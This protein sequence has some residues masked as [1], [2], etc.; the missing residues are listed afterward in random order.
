MKRRFMAA[1]MALGLLVLLVQDVPLA[2]YLRGVET[3]RITTSL[4]RDAFVLAGRSEEALQSTDTADDEAVIAL[5]HQ[6]RASGGARVVIV[7]ASG[8]A[9]VTSDDDQSGVGSTY[10]TRPEI[11]QAMAGTVSNGS[12]FSETLQ[13]K[14][15]YV[16]V[17]VLSGDEVLGAVRL[18]Y[19]ESVVNAAVNE[20]VKRLTI[21]ALTTVVLAGIAAYVLTLSVTRQLDALRSATVALAE[22]DLTSRADE[23]RGAP[24]LRSLS[25]SFNQ[26]ATR[27]DTLLTQQRTFAADA[28]HQLRTPLTALRLRLERARELLA[29][30]PVGAEERL[31]AADVEAERLGTLIEG[32]LLLSRM[33]ADDAEQT[34]VDLAAVALERVEAWQPLADEL[35]LTLTVD[36]AGAAPVLAVASAAEQILDNYIDNAMSASEIGGT[37]Q[38]SVVRGEDHAVMEVRDEGAGMSAEDRGRAFDRFWRAESGSTGTGLGLAIVARLAEASGATVGLRPGT[39]CGLIACAIFR[40]SKTPNG[41]SVSL[42]RDR[43]PAPTT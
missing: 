41:P 15:I 16:T 19:P 42:P 23:D 11:A 20:Q 5:A 32:L 3:D 21:V 6:Y 35:G 25:S 7:N 29:T 37:I 34:V 18:T 40:V 31:A 39:E 38:V 14:L 33:D 2:H 27:L 8:T 28:S 36:A 10:G 4:E 13:M 24:Q 12:R 1:F 30:D 43:V 9:V 22:G 26:M 17:P